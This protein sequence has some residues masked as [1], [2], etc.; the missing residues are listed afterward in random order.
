MYSFENQ[1]TR[2]IG[3]NK[4]HVIEKKFRF[5]YNVKKY[6][7]E[8]EKKI[9]KEKFKEREIEIMKKKVTKP[10]IYLH[11]TLFMVHTCS[12]NVYVHITKIHI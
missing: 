4:V 6:Y 1:I 12:M 5:S 11:F 9:K 8:T 2:Q 10:S 3:Y 7:K